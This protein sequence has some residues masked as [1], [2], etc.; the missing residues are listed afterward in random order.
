MDKIKDLADEIVG[1]GEVSGFVFRKERSDGCAYLYSVHGGSG[2]VYYEVFERRVNSRYNV[3]S[4]PKAKAF[5]IWALTTYDEE[6]A[7]EYFDE[8]SDAV[9]RRLDRLSN[10]L[11]ENV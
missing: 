7:N 2:R 3:V 1:V 6:L 4:Y 5:G 10:T 8:M 9:R 11:D